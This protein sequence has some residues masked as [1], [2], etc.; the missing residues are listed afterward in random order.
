MVRTP[1]AIATLGLGLVLVLAAVI[2]ANE[3][4]QPPSANPRHD[5]YLAT[6]AAPNPQLSPLAPSAANATLWTA[7]VQSFDKPTQKVVELEFPAPDFVVDES[8]GIRGSLRAQAQEVSRDGLLPVTPLREHVAKVQVR[9]V[10]G[11]RVVVLGWKD[12]QPQLSTL[13][14]Q[15]DFPGHGKDAAPHTHGAGTD[16]DRPLVLSDVRLDMVLIVERRSLSNA[17][18]PLSQSTF[19]FGVEIAGRSFATLWEVGTIVEP[20]ATPPSTATNATTNASE[21]TT[22]PAGNSSCANGT[23]PSHAGGPSPSAAARASLWVGVGATATIG[24][25]SLQWRWRGPF[26]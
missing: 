26:A 15:G 11:D 21:P 1:I 19:E 18:P 2:A 20:T 7:R 8:K 23:T 22:S 5:Y 10:E 3:E 24:L 12:L 9:L 17:L 14:F 25:A 4:P 6:D 13:D 16:P